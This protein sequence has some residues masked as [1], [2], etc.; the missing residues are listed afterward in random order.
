MEE[1]IG[2]ILIGLAIL[3]LI[4]VFSRVLRKKSASKGLFFWLIT[5]A[6]IGFVLSYISQFEEQHFSNDNEIIG[7][8]VKVAFF[9][10]AGFVSLLITAILNGLFY[11]KWKVTQGGDTK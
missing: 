7:I 8:V 5:S 4:I 6:S 10:L 2:F 3:G 9:L 1:Y 11:G